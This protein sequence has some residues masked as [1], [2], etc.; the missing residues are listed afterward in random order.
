MFEINKIDNEKLDGF[1]EKAMTELGEFFGKN[2]IK[3]RPKCFLVK[4]RKTMDALH[5]E[6]TEE[7]VVGTTNN[8]SDIYL[9]APD[10][11]EKDSCHN[12]SDEDFFM[13]IKHELAHCFWRLFS[14]RGLPLWMNEGLAIYLSGKI[15]EEKIRGG[16]SDFL[17]Y[18]NTFGKGNYFESGFAVRLLIERFGK[19]KFLE[20]L[21]KL[22]SV[23]SEDE[24][25]DL[26]E[27]VYGFRIGYGK[28]NEMLEE[29]R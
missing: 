10:A 3:N 28:M 26:F 17:K 15:D 13:T 16:F 9:L 14:E 23:E 27:R 1:Y 22:D 21:K 4:D 6:A 2:W 25:H 5:E 18:Y 11:Y 7:W 12:Y 20:L 24:F 8:R 29:G 19:E